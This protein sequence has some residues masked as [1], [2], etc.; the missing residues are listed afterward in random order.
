[1]A[2]ISAI[3]TANIDV[4]T[5]DQFQGKDKNIVIYSCSKSRNPNIP[6]FP[7]KVSKFITTEISAFQK[8]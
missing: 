7:N 5:V 6:W 8:V 3:I 1:M 4:N 2:Q